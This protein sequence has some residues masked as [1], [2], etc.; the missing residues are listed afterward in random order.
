MTKIALVTGANKGIGFET[1]R[2]LG[3]Q[4]HTVL[5]GA[6]DEQR[7]KAAAEKLNARFV[8]LDVT[9]AASIS[10]AAKEIEQ[11][12]G[13]LDILVNNAGIGIWDG[14]P[15]QSSLDALRN[16]FE[17]NLFGVVAVTNA[18]LPL[19]RRS[20]A[21][22]IVNVSSDVGSIALVTDPENPLYQLNAVAYPAS[23][24]ALNMATMQYAKELFDT[25]IKVNAVRLNNTYRDTGPPSRA[26]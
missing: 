6:R 19:L 23:K 21:G 12:L 17:T 22:R 9:D 7:G 5:I 26:R 11:D 14:P 13:V 18:L 2:L 8:R 3:E 20:E 4:G 1:A 16:T 10:A 24:A 25:T 15:S